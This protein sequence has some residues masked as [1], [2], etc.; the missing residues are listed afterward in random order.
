MRFLRRIGR[1]LTARGLLTVALAVALIPLS[2]CIRRKMVVNSNPS[3]ARVYF[4]GEYKGTTPVEFPFKWYGGHRLRLERDGYDN[5]VQVVELRAPIHLKVPFDF[6][7][8]VAPFT[9]EDAKEYHVELESR[10]A[11]PIIDEAS[12]AAPRK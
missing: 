6:F 1:V 9:V 3:G 11:E 8:E 12:P 7:S 5:S 10:A 4:D 2:G